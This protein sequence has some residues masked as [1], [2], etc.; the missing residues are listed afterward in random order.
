[1]CIWKDPLQ[2]SDTSMDTCSLMILT[3]ACR[4]SLYYSNTKR[5][6]TGSFTEMPL[7]VFVDKL[8]RSI[9]TK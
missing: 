5:K 9:K 3:P 1:M 8:D 4:Q 2:K 7:K 6:E